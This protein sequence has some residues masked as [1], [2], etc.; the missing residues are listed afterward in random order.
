MKAELPRR[1]AVPRC[2]GD[3]AS[4]LDHGC[5]ERSPPGPQT[6]FK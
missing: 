4:F 2:R 3:D 1:A 6:F 5:E